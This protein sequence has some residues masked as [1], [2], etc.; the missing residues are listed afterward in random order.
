[1]RL[2]SKD[3]FKGEE[4]TGAVLQV[5]RYHIWPNTNRTDNRVASNHTRSTFLGS[6]KLGAVGLRKRPHSFD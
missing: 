1:M 6:L 4:D 5:D 2:E 3:V